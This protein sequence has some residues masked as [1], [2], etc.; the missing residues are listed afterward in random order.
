METKHILRQFLGSFIFFVIIFLGAGKLNYWQGLLYLG[1]GL[2]MFTLGVT[3]FKVDNAL[4]EER[5]KPGKDAKKWDKIILLISFVAS[6]AMFLVA[7][8][9]SGR[10]HW[11]PVFPI[12]LYIFGAIFTIAGQ[13]LFMIARKQN[14]F[15]SSVVRIQND[16][17]H[18]V[19]DTGLYKIVRHPAYLG[20]VIQLIGFPLIFGS[21]WSII[22]VLISLVLI[23]L[24]IYLEDKTLKNELNGYE[25][26]SKKTKFKLIPL[27]W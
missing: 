22:P 7:G 1:I 25:D 12:Y 9:D 24:R 16:R 4:A 26:Y 2:L 5:S 11:S 19:C 14:S 10:Y 18:K 27:I 6:L 8:L 23:I 13:L 21:L 3:L 20:S 15:F 17:N